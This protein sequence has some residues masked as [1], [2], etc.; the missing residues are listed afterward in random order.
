MAAISTVQEELLFNRK[1]GEE[2]TNTGPA[3][4]SNLANT[5]NLPDGHS[6]VAPDTMYR[7]NELMPRRRE[8]SFPGLHNLHES[9]IARTLSPPGI[10]VGIAISKIKEVDRRAKLWEIAAEATRQALDN[11]P[12]GSHVVVCANSGPYNAKLEKLPPWTTVAGAVT[13]ILMV[14]EFR[15][16]LTEDVHPSWCQVATPIWS[17]EGRLLA[18]IRLLP[19]VLGRHDLTFTITNLTNPTVAIEHMN[20]VRDEPLLQYGA[21][22]NSWKPTNL[23]CWYHPGGIFEKEYEVFKA[24]FAWDGDLYGWDEAMIYS[25]KPIAIITDSKP[26][27]RFCYWQPETV[28]ENVTWYQIVDGKLHG[29]LKEKTTRADVIEWDEYGIP[30]GIL[31]EDA[32]P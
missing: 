14:A 8:P 23:G 13:G 5:I 27:R 17:H 24:S 1:F 25:R 10:P 15:D 32:G 26:N 31:G 30:G 29:G 12:P 11:I 18:G 9:V 7:I 19:A 6:M 20:I 2:G 28:L 16:E 4:K 3:P 22:A 21:V